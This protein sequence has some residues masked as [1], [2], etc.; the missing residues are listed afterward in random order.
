MVVNLWH[1]CQGRHAEPSKLAQGHRLPH[2]PCHTPQ[3][4]RLSLAQRQGGAAAP[5][6][7]WT[8]LSAPV[9][10][11]HAQNTGHVQWVQGAPGPLLMPG[12]PDMHGRHWHTQFSL[13]P[14]GAGVS[15]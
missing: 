12:V 15:L 11:V 6:W 4:K 14:R 2:A 7:C 9:C 5:I 3:L 10:I 8:E 1:A 13:A